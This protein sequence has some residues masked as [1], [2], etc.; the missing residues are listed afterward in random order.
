MV[1]MKWQ[2]SF[3]NARISVGI[4]K[5]CVFGFL[6]LLFYDVWGKC[7]ERLKSKEDDD[8]AFCG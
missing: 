8:Y 1:T 2:I 5:R 3:F 7:H 6:S 4:M